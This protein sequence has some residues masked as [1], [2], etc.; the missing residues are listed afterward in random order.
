MFIDT[1][2]HIYSDDFDA[3][4]DAVVQRAVRAGAERLLLPN[5]DE[6]SIAPM[7]QLCA[8]YPGLCHPMMGLHP[9][10]LP[11]DPWPLLRRMEALLEA[12]RQGERQYVAVGEVG[13]DLYWDASRRE[14]QIEVF[15]YQTGWAVRH[16]LPLVIHCRGAHRELCEALRPYRDDLVGGVFHC[17]GGTADEARELLAFPRFALG[18]GGILTF[19]RSTLPAVLRQAVPLERIVVE[20]DAPYLTPAPYRGRRNEPAMIPYILE[21]LARTYGITPAQDAR[22]TTETAENIFFRQGD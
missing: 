16:R 21:E 13:I 22:A 8:A 3:D 15:R 4:R 10:E 7:L 17:F 11:A 19:K 14:E 6:A 18:V 5:V 9:E 1:H 2:T 12:D 20:T